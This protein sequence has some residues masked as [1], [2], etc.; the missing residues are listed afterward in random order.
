[1]P[2]LKSRVT[3][4]ATKQPGKPAPVEPEQVVASANSPAPPAVPTGISAEQAGISAI[5]A[6]WPAFQ[7]LSNSLK[8]QIVLAMADQA[9]FAPMSARIVTFPD[10]SSGFPSPAYRLEPVYNGSPWPRLWSLLAM[11]GQYNRVVPENWGYAT[12]HNPESLVYEVARYAALGMPTAPNGQPIWRPGVNPGTIVAAFVNATNM[13]AQMPAPAS[14]SLWF[15][16]AGDASR[17]QNPTYI[18]GLGATNPGGAVS[19][20][21]RAPNITSTEQQNL[22]LAH[23]QLDDLW[24][25]IIAL[26]P[27]AGT[28]DR[29]EIMA[30]VGT[31]QGTP[32]DLLVEE[33]A[34]LDSAVSE[35]IRDNK[36]P[37]KRDQS[38]RRDHKAQRMD[39]W[40]F[41][42][43]RSVASDIFGLE[44]LHRPAGTVEGTP[45]T[46]VETSVVV[47]APAATPGPVDTAS[48]P[49]YYSDSPL[50]IR[51][52][53][54]GTDAQG[55]PISEAHSI[56][57]MVYGLGLLALGGAGYGIY[58]AT[59]KPAAK[60][61]ARKNPSHRCR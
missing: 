39:Q 16:P 45:V 3:P 58:Y 4:M 59:R 9:Q 49:W 55:R 2:S 23:R 37:F 32:W 38:A 53:T 12:N 57:P 1:M 52:V 48:A 46:P 18:P 36:I 24:R 10:D 54:T 5:D 51:W 42:W 29:P 26:Y 11:R 13:A 35:Y 8:A 14:T 34:G 61:S 28:R 31:K 27:V 41:I 21:A 44:Q 33:L 40:F 17:W 20:A 47:S 15:S 7:R 25:R 43:E 56:G 22:A 6:A 50:A 60:P 19:K 30:H